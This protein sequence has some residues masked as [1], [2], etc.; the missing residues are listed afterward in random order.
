LCEIV[1]GLLDQL[2]CARLA[3]R[4]GYDIADNDARHAIDHLG[5]VGDGDYAD[6][7]EHAVF[8]ESVVLKGRAR[9]V[10]KVLIVD[11]GPWSEVRWVKHGHGCFLLSRNN[12]M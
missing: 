12:G 8:I 5:L 4:N 10:G 2:T 1:F 9:C 6:L 11:R 7:R 3:R